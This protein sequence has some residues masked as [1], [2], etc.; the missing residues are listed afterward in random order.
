[1]GLGRLLHGDAATSAHGAERDESGTSGADG[2]D[3]VA[4]SSAWQCRQGVAV[5]V[6]NSC[7]VVFEDGEL[8]IR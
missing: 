2:R 7:K 6:T 3:A 1:M 8:H 5:A 4:E